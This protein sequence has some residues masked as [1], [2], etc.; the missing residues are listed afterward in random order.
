[1]LLSLGPCEGRGLSG[2][3]GLVEGEPTKQDSLVS[4]HFSWQRMGVTVQQ[5]GVQL[6]GDDL[7][8]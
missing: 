7:C 5:T 2:S 6:F 3:G 8:G 1:M 4:G